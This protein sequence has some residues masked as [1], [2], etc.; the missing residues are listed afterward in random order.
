MLMHHRQAAYGGGIMSGLFIAFEGGEGAGKSTQARRLHL[1]LAEAGYHPALLHEPGSTELGDYLREYLIARRPLCANSELLLFAAARAELMATIIAPR[2][3]A[4][5]VVIAD[6]FAGSTIAYQGYGRGL[7]R[8][9][10][11]RLNDFATAGRYPDLTILLDIDPQTG[12][13]RV[14]A[15]QLQ[16]DIG[17]GDAYNRFESEE[18]AF[19]HTVRRGFQQLAQT[20]PDTWQPIDANQSIEDIAAQIWNAVAPLLPPQPASA[21]PD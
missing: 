20:R 12:L 21:P 9:E 18:L 2:L 19:H 15:R 16:L 11:D 13:Q 14:R 3:A 7:D 17:A 4:G 6:R 10:I 8:A 1:R 5:A